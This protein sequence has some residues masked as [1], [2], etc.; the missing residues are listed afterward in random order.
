MTK[1]AKPS[2][3]NSSSVPQQYLSLP[4]EVTKQNPKFKS[5][6]EFLSLAKDD[7]VNDHRESSSLR[8]GIMSA[9]KFNY[10][11][12]ILQEEEN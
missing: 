3:H 12:I 1:S 11:A 9:G 8:M 6:M 4:V 7:F 5:Y 10:G 2:A